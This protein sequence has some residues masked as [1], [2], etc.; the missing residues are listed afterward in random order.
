MAI[1]WSD[2]FSLAMFATIISGIAIGLVYALGQMMQNPR[3]N[4]WAKTEIFQVAVSVILVFLTLFMV[5]LIGLDPAADFTISAGWLTA[6]SSEDVEA[7]YDHPSIDEDD[8]VFETS[9]KYLTN[10]A[11]FSHRT[12]RGARAMMGATD[13][14]SKYTRTPCTPALLLCLMGVNGVT[15]RPLSGAAAL[16]QSSN[17][18]LYTATAAYLSVLAQIFFL[19]FIQSG[20]L[21]I[22][23]P[24]AIVIRSL[25]FMRPFGG[26]LIAICLA[27]F[28]LFPMML[29]VESIFWN[30]F[31]WTDDNI[32]DNDGTT[33]DNVD[34]FVGDVEGS[35]EKVA[36][37]DLFMA[38]GAGMSDDW[39]WSEPPMVIDVFDDLIRMTSSAFISSTFLFTFNIVVVSASAVLFARL[40]GSEV[41]LSR[42]VQ[43]V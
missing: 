43:I 31:E 12:V 5:G 40:L 33:W 15:V 28:I 19:R 41:D 42:L 4:V 6:L 20:L 18:F 24:L 9:E 8:N 30:P 14:M 37:G 39:Q 22:Y 16:M 27:L 23:L 25:P 35:S 38:A 13:E 7:V 32:P 26:G 3:L 2:A 11:F 21:V 29:F 1:E 17:V 36:Y 34:D 10:L